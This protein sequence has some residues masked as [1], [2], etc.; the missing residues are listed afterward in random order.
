MLNRKYRASR[1][2]IEE[3]T[4]TGISIFGKFLYAKISRKETEKPGFAI[5]ISKKNEKTSVGRHLIKR[6]IS[7]YIEEN[8]SKINPKFKKTI[9]FFIKKTKEPMDYKEVKKDVEFVLGKAAF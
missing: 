7:S 5:V 2:N 4:K 3:T 9:V 6:K 1:P 8:L